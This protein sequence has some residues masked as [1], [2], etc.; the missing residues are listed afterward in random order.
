MFVG[1]QSAPDPAVGAYSTPPDP[2]TGFKGPTSKGRA[3]QGRGRGERMDGK[4]NERVEE[5]GE[6]K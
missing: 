5:K 4:G 3:G 6:G 1:L 2:F